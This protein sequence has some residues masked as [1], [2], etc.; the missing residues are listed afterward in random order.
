LQRKL[1]IYAL[2][3]GAAGVGALISSAP[4][5]GEVVYT[6]A[7]QVIGRN[8]KYAIDLNHDGITDY[9]L[10]NYF[11]QNGRRGS[12]ITAN[13]SVVPAAGKIVCSSEGYA[14]AALQKGAGIGPRDE[15]AKDCSVMANRM[16]EGSFGTYSFGRWFNVSDLYLG[17]RF[18]IQGQVHYGWARL[19]VKWNYAYWI[20][21]TLTGY[22][23]ETDPNTP[24][25]AGNEGDGATAM[26]QPLVLSVDRKAQLTNPPTL[27]AL[28]L[29]AAGFSLW[30]RE[31][32]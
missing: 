11:F 12:Y 27:S 16:V 5:E 20:V 3:A 24:V 18:E 31:G 14:A 6:P 32:R 26:N 25:T 22:A 21:A 7:H 1:S 29:G 23:Y 10:D 30:R 2:A 8:Q 4:A 13:L 17:L 28:S 15:F 19:T 9:N